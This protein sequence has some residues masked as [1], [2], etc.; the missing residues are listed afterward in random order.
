MNQTTKPRIVF[1]AAHPDDT[2]GFAATA[3]LLRDKYELHVVA[4]TH[5]EKGLG[6]AGLVDGTTGARRTQEEAE[7][8]ALL[9]ATPHFLAEIDGDAY[10]SGGSVGLLAE[11]LRALHP[12]AVFTHWP[13]DGHRDH[14][15]CGI[16]VLDAWRRLDRRFELYYFEVMS[17]TQTQMF[18]PSDWVDITTTRDRKY[19]ASYC[20]VSQDLKEVMDEWHDPMERFRGIECRCAFAEAFLHHVEPVSLV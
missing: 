13:V 8:C 7:A 11:I 1:V 15:V 16:L 2:E 14:A 4:L 17:G 6:L 20:H 12:V 19:K 10:A 3:F 18:H 9:G 5:G